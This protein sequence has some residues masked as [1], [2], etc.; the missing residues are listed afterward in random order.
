M[1]NKSRG[2][3]TIQM[4]NGLGNDRAFVNELISNNLWFHYVYI[5]SE[6]R[7]DFD[8]VMMA[9][10]INTDCFRFLSSK[11]RKNKDIVMN[12]IKNTQSS[13]IYKRI[14]PHIDKSSFADYEIALL[15][16]S[17]DA[18]FFFRVNNDLQNNRAFIIDVITITN[19][20]INSHEFIML[21]CVTKKMKNDLEIVTIACKQ[22]GCALKYASEEIRNTKSVVLIAIKFDTDAFQYASYDMRNNKQFIMEN[23][24]SD[25]CE[26]K[27]RRHTLFKHVSTEL[28]DDYDVVMH[29]VKINGSALE[30]A[31]EKMK[32]TMAIIL[33]AIYSNPYA[34]KFVPFDVRN[35]KQIVMENIKNDDNAEAFKYV[36]TELQNDYDVVLC[37]VTNNGQ[38]KYSEIQCG[39]DINGCI[40][41]Y[42][43]QSK[44]SCDNIS[45]W[46]NKIINK[47]GDIPIIICGNKMDLCRSLKKSKLINYN[48]K[49]N[50]NWCYVS[51]KSRI[52]CEVPFMILIN[53]LLTKNILISKI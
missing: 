22:Y 49:H 42:D 9:L 16:I 8:C 31:S 45:F 41:M 20:T 13:L 33:A 3:V 44:M 52:N 27:L 32:N 28:Q 26:W 46:R 30:F 51:S 50:I 23:M 11:L 10:S 4:K 47:H 34:F 37:A 21:S 24:T 7:N 19:D 38:K 35:N 12:A 39:D 14:I 6:L 5:S 1:Y 43:I 18:N 29:A 17:I 25:K 15:L 36:S 2:W 53:K 40:I 48:V